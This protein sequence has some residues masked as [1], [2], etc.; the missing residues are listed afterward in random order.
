MSKREPVKV[1]VCSKDEGLGWAPKKG[2]FNQPPFF[3]CPKPGSNR[4]VFKGHWILS[5]TRLPIPP[6]GHIQVDFPGK[7]CSSASVRIAKLL[8]FLQYSKDNQRKMPQCF[9][10]KNWTRPK[11]TF[12]GKL[13]IF[14]RF[15][16]EV[17]TDLASGPGLRD[18]RDTR[19]RHRALVRK[20][21]TKHIIFN[22]ILSSTK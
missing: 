11:N 3:W 6:F 5:P 1:P 10:F 15:K 12:Q 18:R 20:R 7:P 4:H 13:I 17:T 22:E 19:K 2:R 14:V 21:T 16:L 8:I 9:L